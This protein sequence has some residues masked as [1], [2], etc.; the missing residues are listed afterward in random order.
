MCDGDLQGALKAL[1]LVNEHFELHP[2]RL[3]PA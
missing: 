1:M 3:T 2:V